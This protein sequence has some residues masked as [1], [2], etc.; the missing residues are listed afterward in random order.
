MGSHSE[1]LGHT[2]LVGGALHRNGPD[3]PSAL[4]YTSWGRRQHLIL[5]VN[6][7]GP[8]DAQMFGS[9]LLL[10]VSARVFKDE[11]SI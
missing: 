3:L 6:L 4:S 7:T 2:N 11:I 9:T 1:V 10:G 5:C 8:L